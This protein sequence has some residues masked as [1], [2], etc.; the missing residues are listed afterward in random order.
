M[1]LYEK[2]QANMYTAQSACIFAVQLRSTTSTPVDVIVRL[3]TRLYPAGLF[4]Q[5]AVGQLANTRLL[6]ILSRLVQCS[7]IHLHIC[8]DIES[9]MGS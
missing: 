2:Q 5:A 1:R 7:L 6:L 9:G 8:K 3:Q 4:C